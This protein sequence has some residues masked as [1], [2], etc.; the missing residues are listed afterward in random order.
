M[1]YPDHVTVYHKL[2]TLPAPDC[3]SFILDVVIL[4]EKHRR[5]AARCIE[6]VVLYDYRKS[7]KLKLGA[8]PFMLDVFRETYELQEKT[9]AVNGERVRRLTKR[10]QALEK[11]SWDREGAKEDFGS[12]S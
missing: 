8:R 12:A 4:S 2:R 9:A 7:K 6:D 5:P 1:T 10:V 11:G 3:D